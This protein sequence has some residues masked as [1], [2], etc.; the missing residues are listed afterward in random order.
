[1]K[2]I[3]ELA[4]QLFVRCQIVLSETDDLRIV[5][6]RCYDAAEAFL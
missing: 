2:L 3:D 6:R 5:S 1:M 4:T